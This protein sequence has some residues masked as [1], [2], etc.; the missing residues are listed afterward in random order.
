LLGELA[1]YRPR[2]E[3]E[4]L[5][6][7]RLRAFVEAEPDCFERSLGS[8]HLTGSAWVVDRPL[9]RALLMHHRKLGKWLQPGGHADG[10][11]DLRRVALREAREESGL[12][13]IALA[14]SSIYDVDVHE[15]PARPGEP[16]HLHYDVRFAFFADPAEPLSPSE[17]SHQVAWIPLSEVERLNVDDSLR[18]LVVKTPE[19]A[20]A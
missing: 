4:R 7:E 11:S 3:R 13:G 14:C 5:M 16:A 17:E 1:A 6:A 2:D 12:R 8:G 9:Q 19:L 18:R 15:I 20:A 10:D